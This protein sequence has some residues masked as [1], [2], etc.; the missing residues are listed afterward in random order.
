MRARLPATVALVAGVALTGGCGDGDAGAPRAEAD[1]ALRLASRG[2]HVQ[3]AYLGGTTITGTGGT[4]TAVSPQTT[5]PPAAE[6]GTPLPVSAGATVRA[7]VSRPAPTL[8]AHVLPAGGAER[9]LE[10]RATGGARRWTLVLPD[11]LPR[12]SRLVIAVT[13]AGGGD[14]TFAAALDRRSS[15]PHARRCPRP[16]PHTPAAERS[17]AVASL[18]GLTVPAARRR[19]KT[20]GCIVRVLERDGQALPA[21]MDLTNARINVAVRDGRVVEILSVR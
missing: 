13:L 5:V 9:R 18:V 20:V 1:R 2:V 16:F 12:R 21:T 8:D 7:L 19:A 15:R 14:A 11:A 17:I 4:R 10:V 6:L 3:A